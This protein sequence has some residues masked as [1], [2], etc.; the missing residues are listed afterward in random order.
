MVVACEVVADKSSKRENKN[1]K[2]RR[3]TTE[4]VISDM[5]GGSAAI[6]SDQLLLRIH[7]TICVII[8]SLIEQGSG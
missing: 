1:K 4:K 8:V 2:W 7:L 3:K 5:C 6:L